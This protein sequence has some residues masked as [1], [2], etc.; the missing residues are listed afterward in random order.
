[1][2]AALAE[3]PA[4][5]R[6]EGAVPDEG[7]TYE[8][9]G[10]RYEIEIEPTADGVRV[11][12][13]AAGDRALLGF[14]PW[15]IVACVAVSVGIWHVIG[16][17]LF[18]ELGRRGA[19]AIAVLAA[20]AVPP[21]AVFVA[22]ALVLKRLRG[23]Q[24]LVIVVDGRE[25]RIDH[26]GVPIRRRRWR[27]ERVTEVRV[28]AVRARGGQVIE[29]FVRMRARRRGSIK[30]CHGRDG[31]EMR[32]VVTVLRNALGMAALPDSAFPEDGSAV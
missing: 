23:G 2:G 8:V 30:F 18:E 15:L 29:Y 20:R 9:P 7:L 16:R 4:V 14:A 27:R 6:V 19:P 31:I 11:T 32:R 12:V 17:W 28:D 22:G 21:V 3:V 24:S 13:P 1:V 25:V 26:P 10:R 5:A